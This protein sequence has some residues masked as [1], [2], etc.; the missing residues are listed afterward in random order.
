LVG[1]YQ[2]VY[3]TG[4][5]A[6]GKS[7]VREALS[8][9]VSPLQV[10]DYGEQLRAQVSR[11]R[12]GDV[13]YE[14]LRSQSAQLATP[15][16]ISALDEHLIGWTETQRH[17]SHIVIDTHAVTREEYGFR[18]TPFS[19][20]QVKRLQPTLIFCLFVDPAIT[21]ERIASDPGGRRIVSEFEAGLHAGLQGSV[22]IGY[23]IALGIPAYFVHSSI[24]TE[25]LAQTIA[26]RIL[27]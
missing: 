8:G 19:L 9:L 6:S 2:V 15:A 13:S 22:V 10:F 18:A 16:D 14:H 23:S 1:S 21:R 12:Q 26:A 20:E 24:P 25:A 5:P 27:R 4:S 7:S 3:L 11:R 17:T